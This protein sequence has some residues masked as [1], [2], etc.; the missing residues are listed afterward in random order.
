MNLVINIML[1]FIFTTIASCCVSIIYSVYTEPMS[2]KQYKIAEFLFWF[3]VALSIIS[4]ILVLLNLVFFIKFL[5][6]W[7]IDVL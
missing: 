1:F 2:N 4:S 3:T 5:I 6:I 7:I